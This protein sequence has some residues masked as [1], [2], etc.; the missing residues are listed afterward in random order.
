MMRWGAA[1]NVASSLIE[2]FIGRNYDAM[3]A[4]ASQ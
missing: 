1:A 3:T 4:A 2:D